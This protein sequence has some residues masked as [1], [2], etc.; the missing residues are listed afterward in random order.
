MPVFLLD[1]RDG[2]LAFPPAHLASDAGL[3]AIGGDLSRKRLLLAYQQGIFPWF[4]E[5]EPVMWWSPDPRLVLYP[6]EL[7][8][9]KSLRKIIMRGL[10]DVTIDMAF[11]AVIHACAH[12]PR[13]DRGTWITPEMID[14]YIDLHGAGFAHSVEAWHEGKL[15]GGLYGISMG[16][17]FFGE[18]MFSQISN[19]SKVAFVTLVTHLHALSF[20]IIDCQVTTAHLKRFGAREI[21][22]KLFIAQIERSIGN[23]AGKLPDGTRIT[24]QT[25]DHRFISAANI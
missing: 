22:R 5:S 18:S 1:D 4:S 14:A 6:S 10:F 21:P 7:K 3:L 9:A 23:L 8:V 16:N 12:I 11:D 2:K 13:K 17:C 20:D 25:H 19:A 15:A 24:D